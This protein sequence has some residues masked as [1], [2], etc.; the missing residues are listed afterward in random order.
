VR[1]S[2]ELLRT[3]GPCGSQQL[4]TAARECSQANLWYLSDLLHLT[5]GRTQ[6]SPLILGV[7]EDEHYVASDASAFLEHTRQ[8]RSCRPFRP[9]VRP[10]V[11]AGGRVERRP[12]V[13]GAPRRSRVTRARR[14]VVHL[15][16]GQMVVCLRG[17]VAPP[18]FLPPPSRTDWTRLVPP[19]VLTGHVSS[20]RQPRPILRRAPAQPLPGA[21]AARAA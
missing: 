13:A 11:R 7:G 5:F 19:P 15:Q 6:G 16:D 3:D 18:P 2:P 14:Q 21:I 1:Q 9:R 20:P 12:G 8:V 17:Q 4:C 10:H